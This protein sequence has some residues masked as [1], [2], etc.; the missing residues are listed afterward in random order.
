MGPTRP[1]PR[2]GEVVHA[3]FR[4]ARGEYEGPARI[5]AGGIHGSAIVEFGWEGKV[6]RIQCAADEIM[7]MTQGEDGP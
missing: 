6:R 4:W 5:V 3:S 1:H 7:S 2:A